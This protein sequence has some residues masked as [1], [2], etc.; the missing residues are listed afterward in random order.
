MSVTLPCPRCG[1]ASLLKTLPLT[2]GRAARGAEEFPP[3]S[4]GACGGLWLPRAQMGQL[5]AVAA[6]VSGGSAA[7]A[8]PVTAESSPDKK[9][10]LCPAGH[11]LMARART[12]AGFALDRCGACG[13]I[14][15]DAGEWQAVAGSM[16]VEHLDQ[17][18]DPAWKKQ[19]REGKARERELAQLTELFGEET[20]AMLVA[21]AERLR[22]QPSANRA[23]AF[24]HEETARRK[25]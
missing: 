1:Q 25:T 4:C 23:L 3:R 15:F 17:L 20:T 21:L 7:P 14:W 16:L 8:A 19:A 18:W 9:A 5:A 22:G 12:D 2:W 11:G 10:A 6:S 13:G 24:L